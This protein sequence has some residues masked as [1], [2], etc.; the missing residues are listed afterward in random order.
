M[1]GVWTHCSV[2]LLVRRRKDAWHKKKLLWRQFSLEIW[3]RTTSK[4]A[5][6][7]TERE[8]GS[9][10]SLIRCRW[11]WKKSHLEKLKGLTHKGRVWKRWNMSL[12]FTIS[13]RDET[14][15]GSRCES[16][17]CKL[18]RTWG[19]ECFCVD[20]L[21]CFGNQTLP[22]KLLLAPKSFSLLSCQIELQLGLGLGARTLTAE[23]RDRCQEHWRRV[24]L[25]LWL[26][27]RS[28]KHIRFNSRSGFGLNWRRRTTTY[29]YHM[30]T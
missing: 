17:P 3:T 30:Y 4:T 5:G 9:G 16:V 7:G 22:L 14:Y 27:Y 18:S 2:L 1:L 11:K 8:R 15:R 23:C 19:S 26:L 6:G 28:V 29:I 24:R 20:P 12:L 13:R 21:I 10:M 25:H